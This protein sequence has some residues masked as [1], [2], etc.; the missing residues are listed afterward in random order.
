[1]NGGRSP[2]LLDCGATSL[3]ALKRLGLD[4]GEIAAIFV[5]HLHGDHFGV[6][7]AQTPI[8][9]LSSGFARAQADPELVR[10]GRFPK[11]AALAHPG[12]LVLIASFLYL[13]T[14]RVL[15]LV[16]LR[17]RSK[18][19]KELEIVVLR[20]EVA[21][22]RRWVDRPEP[23]L[24]ER[25]G[26]CLGPGGDTSSS[27]D[28]RRCCDGTAGPWPDAGANPRRPGRPR[29]SQDVAEPTG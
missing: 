12:E 9:A 22:L 16:L 7:G 23:H 13:L 5:S 20:Q 17:F 27:Y 25:A 6:W 2:V 24:A 29:V 10:R 28:P 15:S 26:C 3:G 21:V 1:M 18:E 14:R 19:Y 8:R 4:P 11:R